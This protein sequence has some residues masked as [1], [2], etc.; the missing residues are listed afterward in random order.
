MH[1]IKNSTFEIVEGL[2]IALTFYVMLY[3]IDRY[4]NNQFKNNTNG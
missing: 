3:I 2:F 1:E 4:L